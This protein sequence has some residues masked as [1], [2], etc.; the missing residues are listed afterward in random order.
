MNRRRVIAVIVTLLLILA[1]LGLPDEVEVPAEPKPAADKVVRAVPAAP[2]PR[3]PV[4]AVPSDEGPVADDV[5]DRL[6]ELEAL[7]ETAAICLV[8]PSLAE[9]SGHLIVG[10]PNEIPYNGRR[11]TVVAGQAFLFHLPEGESRGVLAIEGYAPVPISFT[12]GSPGKP[13]SCTP[14]P[15]VLR[16]GTATISGMVRNAEG[17]PA[18]K[19][20]VEG[21]G[22]QALTDAA[23]DFSMTVSPGGCTLQAFR[24][25][26]LLVSV[27]DPADL[28]PE[29]GGDLIADFALPEVA[30][31]GLGIH[32]EANDAGLQIL[33][34]LPETAAEDVGLQDGDLIVEINGE[35]TAELTL[36][37]FVQIAHGDAGTEVDIVVSRVGEETAY[38]LDRRVLN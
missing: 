8:E 28:L 4:E 25:D 21:C 6:E 9:A 16:V 5:S 13:G 17:E 30:K 32:I 37:E 22:N 3:E 10:D 38:R 27:S 12:Q 14:E 11:V 31:G 29:D 18:G 34:V 1:F 2:D 35:P 23:G 7:D 19:V 15:V 33:G 24:R 36:Q 26:G 20:F